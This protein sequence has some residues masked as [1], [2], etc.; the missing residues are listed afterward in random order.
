MRMESGVVGTL[1]INGESIPED[2]C[3]FRIYGDKGV[4]SL[5]NPNFFGG[6]VK[7]IGPDGSREEVPN[8]LPFSE[9]SRGLGPAEMAQAMEE[10]RANLAN[11]EQALH[12]VSVME[13]IVESTEKRCFVPVKY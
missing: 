8:D 11:K 4:L 3:H 6:P 7:V 2:L 10:G 1:T 12:V 9:N 5:P 13:A